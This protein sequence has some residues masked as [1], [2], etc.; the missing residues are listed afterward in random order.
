M[1]HLCVSDFSVLPGQRQAE[2]F[3]VVVIVRSNGQVARSAYPTARGTCD[4]KSSSYFHK[5][6]FN[7]T[8]PPTEDMCA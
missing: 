6:C 1:M 7:Y 2:L 5:C 4:N 8:S 3:D